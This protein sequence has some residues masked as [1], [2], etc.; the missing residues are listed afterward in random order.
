MQPKPKKM[1]ITIDGNLNHGVTPK[2]VALF[3]I[4]QLTTSGATGYFVEYA[5]EVFRTLSMEGRMT[6]CNLSIEMGARGGMIA[7][8][9]KTFAYIKDRE[10]TPKDVQLGTKPWSYWTTLHTDEGAAF[11]KEFTFDGSEIDPMITF[12]TNPGMGMSITKAIPKAER[13]TGKCSNLCQV[14]RLH[15]LPTKEKA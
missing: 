4:S 7:P 10:F 12:G 13:N 14:A 15:G 6:V 2:D 9:E 3:I 5:G 8:D 11:D 1:R